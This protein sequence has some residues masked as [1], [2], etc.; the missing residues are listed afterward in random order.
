MAPSPLS[1][2]TVA[3]RVTRD[4]LETAGVRT[5]NAET[6]AR[7]LV[8]A[9][10]R[11]VHTHGL[12]R[13]PVYVPRLKS[14]ATRADAEPEIVVDN[15]ST[16]VVDGHHGLGQVTSE[17]AMRR[18]IERATELG[19]G[20]VAVRHSEHFGAAGGYTMLAAEAGMIGISMT[21]TNPHIAPTG[22]LARR[23]G[24]NPL[25]IG[26]PFRPGFPIVLDMAMSVVAAQN[27]RTAVRR[28]QSVP[29]EW[30]LD[31]EGQ[32]STDPETIMRDGMLRAIGDHKGYGLAF[33]IEVLTGVLS[34]GEFG[35]AVGGPGKDRPIEHSHMFLAID[36][37]RFLDPERFRTRLEEL[38]G[39]VHDTPTQKGVD[40]VLLPGEREARLQAERAEHGIPYADDVAEAVESVARDLGVR[41]DADDA[42][43]G[44]G[45]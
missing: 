37:A 13:L 10:L 28:G 43:P 23:V 41:L 7:H 44:G 35:Q 36:I 40:R 19:V 25:S 32:P 29:P 14:G 6:T 3:R 17:F 21:N 30:G 2:P 16:V 31:A 34:G 38:A 45:R 27:L 22:G 11:G 9:D 12:V 18:A 15:G 8:L 1:D 26:V 42:V 20:T 4:I 33:M 5:D 24:N 39:Q